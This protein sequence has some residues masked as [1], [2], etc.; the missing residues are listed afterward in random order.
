MPARLLVVGRAAARNGL[1]LPA[2][3][4]WT[5]AAIFVGPVGDPVADYAAAD[6][7]VLPSF[8]DPFGLVVLEAAACGLPVVTSRSTGASE[9][10]SDGLDGYVLDD[11]ADDRQWAGCLERLLDAVLRRRMGEAARRLALQHT[12]D[13]NCD[14]LL[15]ICR[16]MT[17]THR[18][19]A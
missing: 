18:R 7:L 12:L 15:A 8:Y 10:L 6:A 16:E 19:A 2:A 1:L 17:P 13:R 9:L 3:N 11:P 4:A 5:G 14:V